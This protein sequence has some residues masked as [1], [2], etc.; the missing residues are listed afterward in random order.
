M[1]YQK[2]LDWIFSQLPIYQRS[3]A[4]AY[5]KDI[6]NI[7]EA[8]KRLN[9]PQQKFKSIHIAGT[10]GKGS[11][12]HMMASI[13]QEAGYTTGLYTSPHLK[14]FRER[15]RINGYKIPEAQVMK[16]V[17]NNHHWLNEIGMSFFEMTVAM[18]FNYFAKKKVDISIIETGLGGRLDSTNIL[19]PELCVITNIGLDHTDFLGDTI[20]QIAL[21]KAGIIK[22]NTAVIIGRKQSETITVFQEKA[23]AENAPLSYA[24]PFKHASDLKGNYQEENINTC[25]SSIRKLQEKGWNISEEHIENGL[26]K[27][28]VNTGILGRWQTI[29]HSPLTIC[30][31]GHNEDGIQN[32]LTQIRQT[33]HEQLHIVWGTVNDKNI[34]K[35]LALLPKNAIYYF[36]EANIPRALPKETLLTLAKQHNLKGKH[37]PSV[38]AALTSAQKKTHTKDLIFIGGSTFVVAEVL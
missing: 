21:E 37:Y 19:S 26:K 16:F 38:K 31:T 35:I 18:A 9:N 3:G 27:V 17:S 2:T 6:G 34:E 12:S 4:A 20:E 13:L 14:D 1:N 8:C 29:N 32:I 5:K 7:L 23:K 30:D 36:C 22:K 11:T 24:T 33:P 28:V 15:I 25:V 10:N